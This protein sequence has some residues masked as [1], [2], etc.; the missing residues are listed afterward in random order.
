M[1]EWVAGA[2]GL[3]LVVAAIAVL[4][5][6]AAGPHSPPDI[7]VRLDSVSAA[8]DVFVA[9][10]TAA[11]G[12][13]EPAADVQVEGRLAAGADTL[14]SH[15]VLDYLPGKSSRQGGLFFP[16]DPRTRELR[17]RALGYETP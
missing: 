16:V 17:M 14:V 9:H 11:N 8:R 12:G 13:T 3:V 10:F 1:W 7:S 6:E 5:R 15:A 2:V 4:L